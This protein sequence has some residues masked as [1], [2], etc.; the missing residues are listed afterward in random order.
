MAPHHKGHA[1][2]GHGDDGSSDE[3]DG[4]QFVEARLA[5]GGFSRA[6]REPGVVDTFDDLFGDGDDGDFEPKSKGG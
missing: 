3:D 5:N 2:P 4:I 1:R 6:K